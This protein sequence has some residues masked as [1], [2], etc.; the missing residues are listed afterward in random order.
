[1]HVR[2]RA[3]GS[4]S[5]MPDQNFMIDYVQFDMQDVSY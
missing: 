4:V 1:V 5:A 3:K 2:V